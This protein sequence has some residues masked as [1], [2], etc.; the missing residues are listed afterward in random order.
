MSGDLFLRH[1]AK[2]KKWNENKYLSVQAELKNFFS[3]ANL[4]QEMKEIA[5]DT[6]N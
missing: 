1:V 3:A 4:E 6:I 5:N 2:M